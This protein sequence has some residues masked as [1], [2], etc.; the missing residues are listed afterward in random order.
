MDRST[1]IATFLLIPL[2]AAMAVVSCLPPAADEP[3]ASTGPTVPQIECPGTQCPC[4][5][6]APMTC[7]PHGACTLPCTAPEDCGGAQGETCLGGLCGISCEPGG[8]NDCAAVGMAGG[9]CLIIDRTAVCGYSR[10]G[11]WP[12]AGTIADPGPQHGEAMTTL[13][14]TSGGTTPIRSGAK[15]N[16]P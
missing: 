11:V 14:S 4:P 10:T 5:C 15:E 8:L 13:H 2:P 6:D 1:L 12:R 7:G 16:R 3:A 9:S